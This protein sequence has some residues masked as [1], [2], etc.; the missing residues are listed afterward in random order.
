MIAF[1]KT[2]FHALL[3]SKFVTLLGL[4]G[5]ILGALSDPKFSGLIPANV[6]AIATTAGV[7]IAALSKGLVDANGNGIPDLFDKWVS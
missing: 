3:S 4:G 1:L 5:A 6:A 7:V 2:V